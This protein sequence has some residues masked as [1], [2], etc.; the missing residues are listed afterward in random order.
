MQKKIIALA[1]AGLVSG[2]AFAQSN[3]TVYGIADAGI[4]SWS[5]GSSANQR[6][7]GVMT[8]GMSASRLGFKGEEALGNG[9]KAIF[10]FETAVSLDSIDPAKF[11]RDS[12]CIFYVR[13]L[14]EFLHPLG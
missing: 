12:C 6:T 5:A 3:V 13:V 14:E 7:T 11:I 1:V 4:G 8:G 2:V 10:Q 9:L